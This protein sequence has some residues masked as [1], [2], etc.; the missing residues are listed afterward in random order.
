MAA[1]AIVTR[2]GN[3]TLLVVENSVIASAAALPSPFTLTAGTVF[4]PTI[5]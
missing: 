3:E 5:A 1:R 2:Y 4:I